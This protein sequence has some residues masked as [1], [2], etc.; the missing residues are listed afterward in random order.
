MVEL[1]CIRVNKIL[2]KLVWI[3]HFQQFLMNL[4]HVHYEILQACV[5]FLM[6]LGLNI[7]VKF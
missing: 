5:N 4:Q 1:A 3:G 7:F 2:N 6:D